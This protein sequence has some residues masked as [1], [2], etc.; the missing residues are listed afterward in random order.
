MRTSNSRLNFRRVNYNTPNTNKS[1]IKERV[2]LRETTIPEEDTGM[3]IETPITTK[4]KN[5]SL[6]EMYKKKPES[7]PEP[8]LEK[9][10]EEMNFKAD[11]GSSMF[12]LKD[13]SS[14]MELIYDRISIGASKEKDFY[15]KGFEDIQWQVEETRKVKNQKGNFE[16]FKREFTIPEVILK[17][18]EKFKEGDCSFNYFKD[19]FQIGNA[20]YFVLSN[21]VFVWFYERG[22]CIIVHDFD[23][24]V[25]NLCKILLFLILLRFGT[26]TCFFEGK[27]EK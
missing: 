21:R 18:V 10:T 5:L 7:F 12:K 11:N 6:E 4:P 9:I 25:K 8:D 13:I 2:D 3:K 22:D 23:E 24:V 1:S 17:E 16:A 20:A 19:F 27:R 26:S 14:K 15:N